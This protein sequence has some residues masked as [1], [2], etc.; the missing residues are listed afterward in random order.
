MLLDRT[1]PPHTLLALSASAY[2]QSPGDGT[3]PGHSPD[4]ALKGLVTVGSRRN[5]RKGVYG[6]L[7]SL[8][9]LLADPPCVHL[10]GLTRASQKVLPCVEATLQQWL[11]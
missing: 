8:R 11:G 10:K 5:Q 3:G 2:A 1:V 7:T 9:T 4:G 6:P